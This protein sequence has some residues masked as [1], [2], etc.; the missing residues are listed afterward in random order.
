MATIKGQNLR[1]I[2]NGKCVA[3]STS[4]TLHIATEV[5][6]AS[7]KDTTAGWQENIVVGNSWDASVDSLVIIPEPIDEGELVALEEA[8]LPQGS[9]QIQCWLCDGVID[10]P[11][12]C[13]LTVTS[14]S[15]IFLVKDDEII[16]EQTGGSL[17]YTPSDDA[18]VQIALES[19]NDTADFIVPDTT[20]VNPDDLIGRLGGALVDVRF[21]LTSGAKN[22]VEGDTIVSG[23][24][25]VTDIS[26]N[27]A[28][29]QLS[30]F[31]TQL[32]GSGSLE[33]EE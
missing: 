31:S 21:S 10:I 12:G 33:I 5:Q 19:E 24:A 6:D 22:R 20:A 26:I 23:K 2:I 11:K 32:T 4:C 27:A 15:T 28:N 1:I 13:T 16:D 3:A 18:Q 9:V 8:T 29:R 7:T 14:E 17:T 30:T 25:R